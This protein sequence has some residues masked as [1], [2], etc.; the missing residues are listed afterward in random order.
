MGSNIAHLMTIYGEIDVVNATPASQLCKIDDNI[1]T[2][3][4]Y[5]T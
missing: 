1:K 4:T 2:L 3:I 5:N